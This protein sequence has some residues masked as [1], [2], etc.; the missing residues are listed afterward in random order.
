[1]PI[2]I[3]FSILFC[4]K[5]FCSFQHLINQILKM[6]TMLPPLRILVAFNGLFEYKLFQRNTNMKTISNLV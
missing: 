4:I 3:Q 6:V 2:N 1:M 5:I